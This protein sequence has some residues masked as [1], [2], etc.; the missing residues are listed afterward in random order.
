MRL[1]RQVAEALHYAH[2]K[3]GNGKG[4]AHRGI[5]LNNILVG[6]KKTGAIDLYLSDF[7]LSRIIGTGAVLTRTYLAIAEALGV[8]SALATAKTSQRYPAPPIEAAKMAPLHLSFL[9]NYAS[10]LPS[11]RRSNRLMLSI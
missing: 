4:I 11:K 3:K 6:K 7:G 2:N 1:L 9:Q 8:H 5:K 10:W